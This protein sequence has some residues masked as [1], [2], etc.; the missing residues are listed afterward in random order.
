[1]FHLSSPLDTFHKR[2]RLV[3]QLLVLLL[4]C[5][6]LFSLGG[7]AHAQVFS[8]CPHPPCNPFNPAAAVT[9]ANDHWNWWAY[10]SKNDPDT[11]KPVPAGS[12]QPNFQC[13]E[14]VARALIVGN[15]IPG[16]NANTSTQND[17]FNYRPGDGNT[18]NLLEVTNLVPPKL[19]L[20]AYLATFVATSIGKDLTKA[21]PGDVVIFKDSN[22]TPRH[23]AIIVQAGSSESTTLVDAHNNAAHS[24]PLDSEADGFS[25]Y[26]ILHLVQ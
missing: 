20:E 8:P 15:Y 10:N 9:Y 24:V 13:A 3:S 23:M 18:Y 25:T 12:P 6:A 17:L 14:F 21:T 2:Y 19:T 11:G 16:L 4:A 26:Y 22:G 5:G 1:M 7:K